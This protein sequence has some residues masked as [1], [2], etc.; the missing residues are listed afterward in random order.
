MQDFVLSDPIQLF[1]KD[2]NDLREVCFVKGMVIS[3]TTYCSLYLSK[4]ILYLSFFWLLL[5]GI[6]VRALLTQTSNAVTEIP[7]GYSQVTL[8]LGPRKCQLQNGKQ[9]EIK[10]MTIPDLVTLS[11]I[12]TPDAMR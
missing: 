3:A 6:E 1:E 12:S 11:V 5:L 10:S 9:I 2:T 7:G 8:S 4:K